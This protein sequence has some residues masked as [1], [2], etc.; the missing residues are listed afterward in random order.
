M[1]VL[2]LTA[3]G[4]A[5][6]L[7]SM[8]RIKRMAQLELRHIWMVWVGFATQ[9]IVFQWVGRYLTETTVELIH[10]ATYVILIAFIARNRHI[11]GSWMI[12]LGS[13]CNFVA[14]VANGG[15][16]PAARG[17]V[18]TAGRKIP[19]AAFQNSKALSDPN[20]LFLGDVFAVPAG[21]PLANVFSIGDI[22]I[23]IGGTYLAHRWCAQRPAPDTAVPTERLELSL[24]RT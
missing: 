9:I 17:A 8:D 15:S 22:L 7:W 13:A 20:L 11:P 21:W 14:I 24:T 5:S 16:M 6:A 18:E 3:I 2:V 23:V 10:V 1:I 19:A 4:V 12:A